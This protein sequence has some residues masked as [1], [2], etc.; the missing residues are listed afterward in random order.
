MH[1]FAV[2]HWDVD[3][4]IKYREMILVKKKDEILSLISSH[5]SYY[6]SE[7][8]SFDKNIVI[9]IFNFL[10]Y[11][12]SIKK[13]NIKLQPIVVFDDFVYLS[14]S[15]IIG[16]NPEKNLLA[17]IQLQNVDE[18]HFKEVNMLESLM[19]NQI[20]QKLNQRWSNIKVCH[21]FKIHNKNNLLSDLDL[22]VYDEKSK[23]V[24]LCELKW[25]LAAESPSEV[26]AR[27]D[28][29]DHGCCQIEKIKSFIQT[30]LFQFM[31]D[32]FNVHTNEKLTFYCCVITK[33]DVRSNSQKVPVLSLRKFCHLVDEEKSVCDLFKTINSRKYYRPQ[34]VDLKFVND[35][36]QYAGYTFS[37]TT[38]KPPEVFLFSGS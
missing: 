4:S 32:A 37:I 21:D 27:E 2:S 12:P 23:S 25:L 11:N 38:F 31:N 15:L 22:G 24:L 1:Y 10:T 13:C 3:E 29:V 6:Q 28:D 36:F 18:I 14:P 20:E 8:A 17:L 7:E 35:Y 19:Y 26:Y 30:H 34:C 5:M 16:D 9:K 33:F